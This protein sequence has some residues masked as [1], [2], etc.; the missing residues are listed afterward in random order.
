MVYF[1]LESQTFTDARKRAQTLTQARA[2]R[3]TNAQTH[4]HANALLAAGASLAQ[5]PYDFA[6]TLSNGLRANSVRSH[7]SR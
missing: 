7:A 1:G 5:T 3:R 6:K 2:H 4:R